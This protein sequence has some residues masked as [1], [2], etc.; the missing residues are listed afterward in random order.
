MSTRYVVEWVEN[1]DTVITQGFAFRPGAVDLWER[2]ICC[3]SSDSGS[4]ITGATI[5]Y[6]GPNG[7]RAEKDQV[8][9]TFP[10]G[11]GDGQSPYKP[12]PIGGPS[13]G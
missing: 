7:E 1:G 9:S 8:S 2:L 3:E 10:K 12:E 5:R 4:G 11:G 13:L 6:M